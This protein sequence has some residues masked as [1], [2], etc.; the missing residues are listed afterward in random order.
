MEVHELLRKIRKDRGIFQ[1]DLA[2]KITFRESLVKYE[3]EENRIPLAIL[4]EFLQKMNIE[5]EEFLFYLNAKK[6]YAK[7]K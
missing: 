2:G 3:K 1:K 4:L 7:N 5:L 6:D